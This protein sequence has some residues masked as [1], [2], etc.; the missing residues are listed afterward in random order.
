MLCNMVFLTIR[1]QIRIFD[2]FRQV[3]EPFKAEKESKYNALI[4]F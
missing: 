1:K 2:K 4:H 3:V